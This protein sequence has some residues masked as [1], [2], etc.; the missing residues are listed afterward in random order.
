MN[1]N[2]LQVFNAYNE[3][4]LFTVAALPAKV[5]LS[6]GPPQM[7]QGISADTQPIPTNTKV[8]SQSPDESP[9]YDKGK[10]P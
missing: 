4:I 9:V 8:Q 6:G 10:G 2:I 3:N 1:Q 7:A 5:T